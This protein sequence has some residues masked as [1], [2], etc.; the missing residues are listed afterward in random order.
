MTVTP[1]LEQLRDA[2]ANRRPR[3]AGAEGLA[4]LLRLRFRAYEIPLIIIPASD[5]ELDGDVNETDIWKLFTIS[6]PSIVADLVDPAA[7]DRSE[8]PP[9]PSEGWPPPIEAEWPVILGNFDGVIDPAP[10][11]GF[12][13]LNVQHGR[14]ERLSFVLE[15]RDGVHA[16]GF[17]VYGP[18]ERLTDVLIAHIGW[19]KYRATDENPYGVVVGDVDDEDFARYLRAAY[20]EGLLVTGD[21]QPAPDS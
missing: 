14:G 20:A 1:T 18:T 7:F 6:E 16:D 17:K 21:D 11:V 2:W 19:D 5:Y 8:W 13:L 4:E 3:P 15:S 12:N 9:S 10:E